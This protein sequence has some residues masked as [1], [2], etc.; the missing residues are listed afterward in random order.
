MTIATYGFFLFSSMSRVTVA[1]HPVRREKSLD[2]YVV[3][4]TP[5]YQ[6]SQDKIIGVR[7]KWSKRL[8]KK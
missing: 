7:D 3:I 2:A 8:G 4:C 5:G 1:V 6:R